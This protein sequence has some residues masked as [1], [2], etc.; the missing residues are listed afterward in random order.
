MTRSIRDMVLPLFFHFVCGGKGGRRGRRN[1]RVSPAGEHRRK[2]FFVVPSPLPRRRGTR[3]GGRGE[4]VRGA[5]NREEGFFFLFLHSFIFISLFSLFSLLLFSSLLFFF[6][7]L[8]RS[9]LS[10]AFQPSLSL[11]LSPSLDLPLLR[12]RTTRCFWIFF[13]QDKNNTKKEHVAKK[14]IKNTF[15]SLFFFSSSK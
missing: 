1:Q 2:F 6:S 15:F 12:I 11:S 10:P 7:S 14:E 13:F 5:Q 4:G 3:S 8:P 9:T